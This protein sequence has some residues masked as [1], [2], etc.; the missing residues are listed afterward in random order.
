MPGV[1]DG[2]SQSDACN[3]RDVERLAIDGR[4]FDDLIKEHRLPASTS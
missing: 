4:A 1:L 2:S 3:G